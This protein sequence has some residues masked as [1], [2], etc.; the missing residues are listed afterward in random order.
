[1]DSF[2]VDYFDLENWVLVHVGDWD[3][4]I[5]MDYWMFKDDVKKLDDCVNM[6]S[7]LNI[8]TEELTKT[9]KTILLNEK[10]KKWDRV[11][12]INQ[13]S[14][15]MGYDKNYIMD[16]PLYFFNNDSGK[17]DILSDTI[18]KLQF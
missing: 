9:K 2:S 16:I 3:E 10:P 17:W 1:M 13:Y 18:K 15:M 5:L 14:H 12:H 11:V 6:K 7:L 4:D 8:T